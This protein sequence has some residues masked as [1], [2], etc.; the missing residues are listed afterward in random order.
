MD[1]TQ[2]ADLGEFIGGVAVLVTLIYLAVQIRQ[3]TKIV[4]AHT[5]TT[6]YESWATFASQVIQDPGV[7]ALLVAARNPDASFSPEDAVRLEWLSVRLFGQWENAH[8]QLRDGVF[9]AKH[10]VAYDA[11]YRE[12]TQSHHFRAH[13]EAHRDWYFEE[14]VRHVDGTDTG[15]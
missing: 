13:W 3:N 12:W 10:W 1:L 14:F 2:L 11:L 9:D 15:S 6:L 5:Q 4:A 7:A 8:A